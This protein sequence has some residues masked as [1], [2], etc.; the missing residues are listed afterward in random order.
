MPKLRFLPEEFYV[1]LLG[2][3]RWGDLDDTPL[4]F[5]NG[6]RMKGI[7][8]YSQDLQHFRTLRFYGQVTVVLD[9]Q[10]YEAYDGY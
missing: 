5:F 1:R 9:M 4:P 3:T 8:Q 2:R 10:N 7:V 6:Y